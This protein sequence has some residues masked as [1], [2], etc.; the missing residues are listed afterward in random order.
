MLLIGSSAA[1]ARALDSPLD[2]ALRALLLLRRAQLTEHDE[3]DLSEIAS[4]LI[5]EAGDDLPEVETQLGFSL[6]TNPIDERRYGDSDFTPFWEWIHASDG[7]FELVFVL[8]DDG[9]AHVVFVKDEAGVD[10][11]LLSLCREKTASRNIQNE[12]IGMAKGEDPEAS[13]SIPL[14]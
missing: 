10:P 13:Q 9:F 12:L 3:A 8:T 2:G 7:W 1:M 11:S 14:P 6:L 4:F 5:V